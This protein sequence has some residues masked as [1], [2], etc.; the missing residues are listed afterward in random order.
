MYTVPFHIIH[1]N[2]WLVSISN[3]GMCFFF[4]LDLLV[5]Y[6]NK[7]NTVSLFTY[8]DSKR[9]CLTNKKKKDILV[10]IKQ[11]LFKIAKR[12]KKAI[13]YSNIIWHLFPAF[14]IPEFHIDK[15]GWNVAFYTIIWVLIT[16][17][18]LLVLF[19]I[20]II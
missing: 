7:K 17:D 14:S 16:S 18:L 13:H 3:N 11:T 1:Y 5:E 6:W 15:S 4:P 19:L 2:S 8:M 9:S 20:I 10:Y 12:K